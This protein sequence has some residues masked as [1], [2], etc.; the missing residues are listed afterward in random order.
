MLIRIH[1]ETRPGERRVALVPKTV[2]RLVEAGHR[3]AL[4]AGAGTAAGF[5]DDA[6]AEAG[7][8]V[9]EGDPPEADLVAA[10]GPVT[11]EDVASTGAVVSFL[12][13]LGDPAGIERFAR[14]GI[15][16]LAMEM[17]P[18]TTLAQSMDALSSQANVAGYEAVILGAALLPRFLPMMMTAAGTIPPA[19]VL[20]LGAGVAGLQAIATARRLGARVSGYDIRP[21]AAEQIESLGATFVGGPLEE[22][23]AASGGYASEVSEETKA[24][25]QESLA[26][27]VADSDLVVTTAQVPGR[28]A[29]RLVTNE[30]VDSMKPGS[31]IVD[32]AASTG[33]NCEATVAGETVDRNGVTVAGPLDLA[34]RTAGHASEMYS[35]NVAELIEYLT[36]DAGVLVLDPEDEIATCAVVRDG[37]ITNE[38]VRAAL[39]GGS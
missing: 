5:P 31:V 30:M 28:A 37:E 17:I 8:E 21:E 26:R 29:P 2:K 24:R 4:P 1:R 14:A 7:A 35:R 12:N 33:G 34:S 11:A 22:Q 13:P 23:D 36:D 6:Y 20:V 10:V 18:R 32:L 39:E 19:R 16:A 3:V 25:Q 38:R 27:H 15:D 9:F